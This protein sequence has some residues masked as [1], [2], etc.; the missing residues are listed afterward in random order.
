[1]SGYLSLDGREVWRDA[2]AFSSGRGAHSGG[3]VRF[4]D[5]AAELEA[6]KREKLDE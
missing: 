1:M 2:P 5:I 4:L 3:R 6:A